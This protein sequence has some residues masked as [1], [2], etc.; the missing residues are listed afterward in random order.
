MVGDI[1]KK[2]YVGNRIAINFKE[3][4]ISYEQLDKKVLAFAAYLKKLGIRN[5]DRVVLSCPNCPEFV[6]SYLGTVRGGAIIV[7]INLLLTMGEIQYIVN[8]CEAK[9]MIV[10]QNI[11]KYKYNRY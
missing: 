11:L 10:H 3:N 9:Y 2:N 8:D 4:S 7:P 1:Y 6:Y 5:G